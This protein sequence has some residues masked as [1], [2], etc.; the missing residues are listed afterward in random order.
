MS[1]APTSLSDTLPSSVPKLDASSMNWAIFAVRFQDAVE[2]K[3]F[4]GHFT[5]TK[6]CS[7]IGN[8]STSTA[9]P[10]TSEELAVALKQWDKDEL[11]RN[12]S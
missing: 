4:W 2:A 6:T 10:L 8:I 7:A 11:P 1:T 5:S 12:P 9:E 3:G